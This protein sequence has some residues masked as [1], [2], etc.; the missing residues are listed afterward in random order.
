MK[1]IE[2]IRDLFKLVITAMA[3][4]FISAMVIT[5]AVTASSVSNIKNRTDELIVST[6]PLHATQKMILIALNH[7]KDYRNSGNTESLIA[8][9]S[10]LD[11]AKANTSYILSEF[12][13]SPTVQSLVR[14]QRAITTYR[15]AL[16][17][18]T[19]M[20]ENAEFESLVDLLN[21][22][23]ADI[24]SIYQQKINQ[25]VESSKSANSVYII[26]LLFSIIV[27]IFSIAFAVFV[28][29]LLEKNIIHP[30]E[31]LGTGIKEVVKG[32]TNYR[33]TKELPFEFK[34]MGNN[35]NAIA[36]KID[37]QRDEITMLNVFDED[38]GVYNRREFLRRLNDEVERAN[39]YNRPLT[40]MFVEIRHYA[41][42]SNE[43]SK[44]KLKVIAASVAA[45]MK[46]C[47][48]NAD[49]LSRVYDHR[50]AIILPE[51]T[52]NAARKVADKV[53]HAV[54]SKAIDIGLKQGYHTS[55]SVAGTIYKSKE[56]VIAFH[57][58][59][60]EE[61]DIA[62]LDGEKVSIK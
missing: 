36:D 57:D 50:F 42:L 6:E 27:I 48:R 39:R 62:N 22:S 46:M 12:S 25:A 55:I 20:P 28:A 16:M 7:L 38:T 37:E 5:Q 58:R 45:E 26:M 23:V 8:A 52:S 4:V 53:I 31:K 61:I 43:L 10:L 51:T 35:V 24:E 56:D 44:S 11:A 13:N 21:R 32:K 30:L 34:C 3:I 49:A 15:E 14:K 33:I 54:E 17:K 60:V 40:L 2:S 59:A 18:K 41:R 1:K 29:R 47:L 19:V 9:A